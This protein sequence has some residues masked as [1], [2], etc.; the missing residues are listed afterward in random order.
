MAVAEVHVPPLSKETETVSPLDKL[1]DK[2]PLTVCAAVLVMKSVL[3]V[4]VSAENAALA[5]VRVGAVVSTVTD[6][7]DE[8]VEVLPAASV[9]LAVRV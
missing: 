8:A 6:N 9:A 4:P 3:L 5:T 2:V 1:A 7:D